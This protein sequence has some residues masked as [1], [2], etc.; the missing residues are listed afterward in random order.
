MAMT[1]ESIAE[2][3]KLVKKARQKDLPFGLCLGKKPEDNVLVL[4][5]KKGPEVLMR[6]AKAEGETGKVTFGTVGVAGKIMSVTLQGKMLPGLAKNM[7]VFLSKIG[8]KMKVVILDETGN[9]LDSDGDDSDDN[10]LSQ[11]TTAA[12]TTDADPA[13]AEATRPEEAPVAAEPEPVQEAA[14]DTTAEPAETPEAANWKK[15]RADFDP[16]IKAFAASNDPKA[17]AIAKAWQGAIEAAEAEKFNVATAVAKKIG[18][19]LQAAAAAASAAPAEPEPTTEPPA[20]APAPNPDA[21]KWAR[22]EGPIGDL[23]TEVMKLNPPEATKLRSVWMAATESAQN[24]DFTKGVAIA[25]RL[26]P[27]LDAAKSAGVSAQDQEIPTDVVPFHK[28]KL[29]WESARKKMDSEISGLV[30]AIV[31]ACAGDEDLSDIA[32]NAKQLAD[33]LTVFETKLE[34]AL[35]TIIN[36]PSGPQRDTAKSQ[37]VT[38]IGGFQTLLGEPFFQD[39]D[40]NNGFKQVKVTETAS[41]SLEA[42]TKILAAQPASAA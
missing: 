19:V 32:S 34:D 36:T 11:D 3:E 17:A 27:M 30:T 4:D 8:I 28:S 38:V 9:Q 26:K 21:A 12:E 20:E 14:A 24:N 41:K 15:I 22:I 29:A 42:I 6:K 40:A 2:L 23:Y 31:D 25:T 1:T 13:P 5:L 33:R 37:A 39:V 7:K 10:D 16:R 18:P 35:N